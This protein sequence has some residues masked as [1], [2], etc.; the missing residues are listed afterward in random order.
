VVRMYESRRCRIFE[1]KEGVEFCFDMIFGGYFTFVLPGG[2]VLPE[3]Q[4]VDLV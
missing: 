2:L 3:G 1:G 4:K